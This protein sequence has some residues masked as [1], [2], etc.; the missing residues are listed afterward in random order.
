M[1][2]AGSLK[3]RLDTVSKQVVSL[4]AAV[5]VIQQ[6]LSATTVLLEGMSSLTEVSH[7]RRDTVAP[8]LLPDDADT[9]RRLAEL[10]KKQLHL[11]DNLQLLEDKVADFR[12]DG[13]SSSK[14]QLDV[15][16][17]QNFR[18]RVDTQVVT[19]V[20]RLDAMEEGRLDRVEKDAMAAIQ[21]RLDE[22]VRKEVS[23]MKKLL[24]DKVSSRQAQTLVESIK[25]IRTQISNVER[26]QQTL[27]L[28][29]EEC[30]PELR[31]QSL[32]GP[33]RPWS[34][35]SKVA[36]PRATSKPAEVRRVPSE[37]GAHTNASGGSCGGGSLPRNQ[38]KGGIERN[39]FVHETGRPQSATQGHV[40]PSWPWPKDKQPASAQ[41]RSQSPAGPKSRNW[42][43]A[44]VVGGV[45]L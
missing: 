23:S 7:E 16:D 22:T 42:E 4:D 15:L 34:S 18:A 17:E 32:G 30:P 20:R 41:V 26:V 24:Q 37:R 8:P 5:A 1:E 38:T 12:R 39:N 43:A 9:R 29:P 36:E 11:D 2:D 33:G 44:G 13:A 14:K 6:R 10:E 21:R 28:S 35:S 27:Q 19:L 25:G 45:D 31:L 40:L 3:E